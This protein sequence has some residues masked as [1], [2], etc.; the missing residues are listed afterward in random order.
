MVTYFERIYLAFPVATSRELR[1]VSLFNAKEFDLPSGKIS[2]LEDEKKIHFLAW[3]IKLVT[4]WT[5]L[6]NYDFYS[7]YLLP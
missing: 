6:N 1:A 2:V 4:S 7:K 5:M 3:D